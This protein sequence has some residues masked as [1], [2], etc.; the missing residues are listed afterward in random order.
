MSCH[1]ADKLRHFVEPAKETGDKTWEGKESWGDTGMVE[2]ENGIKGKEKAIYRL[3][4]QELS[5]VSAV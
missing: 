1:S 3:Q 4:L 5:V 2:N